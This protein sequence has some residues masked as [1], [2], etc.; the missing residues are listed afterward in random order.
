LLF[1]GKLTEKL[2]FKKLFIIGYMIFVL[3]HSISKL[4]NLL[5][6]ER[7]VFNQD[8]PHLKNKSNFKKMELNMSKI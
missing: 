1:F 7:N 3:K 8:N 4:S 6:D 2:Y 5:N